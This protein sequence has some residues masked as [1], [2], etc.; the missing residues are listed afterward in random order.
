VTEER[1]T[2]E[3]ICE[4]SHVPMST[5]SGSLCFHAMAPSHRLH[6]RRKLCG[7][8][9]RSRIEDVHDGQGWLQATDGRAI[10]DDDNAARDNRG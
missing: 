7:Q 8:Q 3:N 1:G 4:N 9:K 6:S 10:V 2:E 5:S